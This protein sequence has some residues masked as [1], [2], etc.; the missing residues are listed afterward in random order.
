M[1]ENQSIHSILES[2]A[3]DTSDILQTLS[4][5]SKLVLEDL[6]S[7]F[8]NFQLT[9]EPFLNYISIQKDLQDHIVLLQEDRKPFFQHLLA[10][11]DHSK[12]QSI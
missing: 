7:Q 12:D 2:L 8:E 5:K 4:Q 6:E 9:R 10:M 3:H 1:Q 11:F